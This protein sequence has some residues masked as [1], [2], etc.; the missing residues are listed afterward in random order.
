[1]EEFTSF[2]FQDDNDNLGEVQQGPQ[3]NEPLDLNSQYTYLGNEA[4]V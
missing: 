1:M 4:T 2:S 3:S